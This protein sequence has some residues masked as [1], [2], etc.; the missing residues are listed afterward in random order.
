MDDKIYQLIDINEIQS[1]TSPVIAAIERCQTQSAKNKWSYYTRKPVC[2]IDFES[3]VACAATSIAEDN[4][5]LSVLP[6]EISALDAIKFKPGSYG[7]DIRPKIYDAISKSW[8]LLDSGS[9]VSCTSKKPGDK[10]D[11]N[12]NLKSVNGGIIPTYGQ[13]EL[14]IRLGRKSYTIQAIKVDIQQ[15]ILGWDFF[16][17]TDFYDI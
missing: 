17:N 15:K 5:Y 16:K 11:P 1:Y 10:I 4:P 2:Q 9:C 8:V 3:K 6:G 12:F 13:E 14:E 7:M